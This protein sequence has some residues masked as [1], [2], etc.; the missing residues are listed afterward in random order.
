MT[1]NGANFTVA[2]NTLCN[3]GSLEKYFTGGAPAGWSLG[4]LGSPSNRLLTLSNIQYAGAFRLDANRHGATEYDRLN[5]QNKVIIGINN[6]TGN[7]LVTGAG[8]A[9]TQNFGEFEIPALS[10]STNL[11]DL[12]IAAN[13]QDFVNVINQLPLNTPDS[14]VSGGAPYDDDANGISIYGLFEKDNKIIFHYSR[15]YDNADG[16]NN[17]FSDEVIGVKGNA[18]DISG[19]NDTSG[20]FLYDNGQKCCGWISPIPAEHQAALGGEHLAG[21]SNGTSRGI[22]SRHSIG[23]SAY[24]VDLD[25]I[26]NPIPA[27]GSTIATEVCMDFSYPNAMGIS[28]TTGIDDT[29]LEAGRIW[30]NA[31]ESNYG[32]IVPGTDTYLVVGHQ[33][34]YNSGLSYKARSGS[35]QTDWGD[36]DANQPDDYRN[37]YYMFDVNDLI[38]AK[39][40]QMNPHDIMPYEWGT[41]DVPFDGSPEAG[42]KKLSGAT[43]DPA[44]GR[45]YVSLTYADNSQGQLSAQP[46]ICAYTFGSAA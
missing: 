13:T 5:Y 14:G 24:V 12:N 38:A 18:T 30:N 36:Y 19:A 9:N 40:G 20:A 46:L 28:D 21:F 11:T 32:F 26:L 17:T 41:L 37:V 42:I 2:A 15:Y 1:I 4:A 45:L 27:N 23:P 22:L 44:T 16:L 25:D 3:D 8:E 39:N 34:G 35:S 33:A 6:T 31:T 29:L 43:F 7:M 10:T